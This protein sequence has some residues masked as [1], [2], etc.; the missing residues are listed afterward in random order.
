MSLALGWLLVGSF[1]MQRAVVGVRHQGL[2]PEG[3]SSKCG[4]EAGDCAIPAV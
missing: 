1:D 4:S 3:P 2:R